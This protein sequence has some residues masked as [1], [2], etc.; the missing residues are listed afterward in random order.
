M[1]KR[2][3]LTDTQ[4]VYII[5]AYSVDL[6]PMIELA[7]QHGV[8]RQCIHKMLRKAGIE[9]RKGHATQLDVSCSCC[10]KEFKKLR[11]QVRRFLHVFCSQACY[12]AYLKHGNGNPLIIHRHSGRIA[13]DI[14]LKHYALQP[15]NIVHH[16]DRNQYNN[17]LYN[18]K[19]FKNNGDH[20]RH[21][22]GFL[23]PILWDGSIV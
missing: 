9:T 13:R 8:T 19:V 21:H 3:I 7:K 17:K 2:V 12:T 15:G 14:V 16:E 18:L 22:R 1:Y 23:V 5:K 6:I 10:G 11:C 20:V 4:I